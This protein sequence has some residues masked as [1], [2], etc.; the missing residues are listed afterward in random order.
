MDVSQII[1]SLNEEQRAAVTAEAQ[2]LVVLAGAGSGKTR[3][4]VH[5]IAWI[6]Q[7]YGLSPHAILAVTFTN[8]AA[9]EMK[10]R[11]EHLLG[12]S[13]MGMWVGTFHGLSH[14]LLRQHS[15][16]A[17]LPEGFGVLD[18]DDQQRLIKRIM[19][20]LEIDDD[21]FPVRQVQHYI[22]QKKDEGLRAAH[23]SPGY[24]MPSRTL[25][26]IYTA[27]EEACQRMGL[28]DF[29]ELLLRAHELWRTHPEILA[30]YRQRFSHILVDEF[31]DTNSIQ[32]AWLRSLLGPDNH[33]MIVGDD[34]QSIY[35]W[36][37][38]KDNIQ[39]FTQDFPN[40]T[41][42][43][44]E[45][46]Y[47]STQTILE[48]ANHLIRF[49]DNRMGKELWT[50]AKG[51]ELID[52]YAAF[53][54][55][56]EAHYVVSRIEKWYGTHGRYR[57]AAILYRSNAQSR[58]LEEALIRANIPYRI[59]G[60]LRFFER[61]EI[62]DALAYLRL[63]EHPEDD[64]A[65]ERV[66]NLPVR[67]I[68]DRTL[69]EVRGFARASEKSLWYASIDL[70][71]SSHFS[72]R[73]AGALQKFI[74]LIVGIKESLNELP[75]FEQIATTLEASGLL[76]HYRTQ[77]GEKA[78]AKLENLEELITAGQQFKMPEHDGNEV[79]PLQAFI[80]HA[81]LEAGDAQ[82]GQFT[83]AVQLMTLHSAKGLE[84]P[85]VCMTGLEEGLFPHE[86]SRTEPGRLEEERRLCY[87]GMTRA[88]QKLIIVYAQSRMLHGRQM[89]SRPSRFLSEMPADCLNEVRVT[90]S[91]T[92]VK[93]VQ[94]QSVPDCPFR[95]GARVKHP[96]F[97]EGTVMQFEGEGEH[98]RVQV[99]FKTN[100]VKWLVLGYARL[101]SA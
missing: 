47:R 90:R 71:Q 77:K 12:F 79:T 53:S 86:M 54:E 3:V 18:S 40:A 73:A 27:Y 38:A 67:G 2:H 23:V 85:L 100:G 51:G 35:G 50:N 65:F 63:L 26:A 9:G 33:M 57:D 93:Q 69:D 42:V 34:D 41:I 80:S 96:K 10:E 21:R 45:Q 14:R 78:Q 84:F 25:H 99:K 64:V 22:G 83:D 55:I 36:R 91:Q 16:E 88:M 82:A 20:Q 44:L 92:V 62:K 49:N 60:G 75:L 52:V 43:R 13:L 59:F 6:V 74:D 19:K 17:G 101:E 95:L 30:H 7:Q 15:A 66:V 70:L 5:R 28:V 81:A 32:Y 98:A 68:G 87:V 58:V 8:K 39:R 89:H 56:D 31:Q 61:A 97:G 48:A 4:L 37:G 24:D 11:I 1:G 29:A 72:A 94:Q 76:E 46:N